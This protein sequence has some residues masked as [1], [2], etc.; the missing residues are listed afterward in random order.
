MAGRKPKAPPGTQW[1]GNVLYSEFQVKGKPIRISLKTDDPRV[2]KD[3]VEKLRKQVVADVYHGGGPRLFIDVLAEWRAF[4][5][6]KT[7]GKWDG[8]VGEKTFTRYCVSLTQLAPFLEDKKLSDIDGRLIGR[9]V[10][11]RGAEVTK[12]TVKRDLGALSS[13][14]NF[15]VAH[16]YRDNNPV[17]PWLKTV[18][19]R[20]DPIREPRDQ[21]IELMISRAR[22]MWPQLIRA[23]LVTGIR[24]AALVNA[25]REDLN[26]ERKELT[27][28]DKG[29]K[30]RVV[31]LQP[32]GGYDVF[33]KLPAFA[34]KP[35]LFWRTEDKRVRKDSKR[36]ATTIG[37]KIEDPAACFRRE[38][39]LVATWAE[40]NSVEFR[41]FTFHHLRHKHAIV[42]LRN[43]GNI[44]ELQQR[45][46]HSSIKQT[47]EYLKYVKGE[48]QRE[49]THGE[50][51]AG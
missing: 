45:L 21:D 44:Y 24:E 39:A 20:R 38:V 16:E 4:M 49:N 48:Q 18:K 3:A 11:E 50:R 22:G 13:V 12:A 25:K 43:G 51:K 28:I 42:W 31:D 47:E 36:D 33:A 37:D 46:G 8:Q 9:I 26:H 35:W 19:E 10:R 1:R 27:V 41:Q 29:N 32:M 34:G 17:L 2:A 6:G 30:V 40:E 14:M 15:A 5:V 7:G 23:A